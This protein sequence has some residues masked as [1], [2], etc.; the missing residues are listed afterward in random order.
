MPGDNDNGRNEV[1]DVDDEQK[2][3]N[4]TTKIFSFFSFSFS[5]WES[6]FCIVKQAVWEWLIKQ[7][8]KTSR[9]D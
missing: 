6:L 1:Q 9:Y 7:M 5:S 8:I 4:T 2:W 3:I